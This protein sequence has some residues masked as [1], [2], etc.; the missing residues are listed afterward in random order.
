[1]RTP[2]FNQYFDGRIWHLKIDTLFNRLIVEVRDQK[3]LTTS[4]FQIDLNHLKVKDLEI[5]PAMTWFATLAGGCGN[6]LVFLDFQDQQNPG[7]GTLVLYDVVSATETLR[8]EAFVLEDLSDN[9]LSGYLVDGEEKRIVNYDLLAFSDEAPSDETATIQFP[10]FI[11]TDDNDFAVINDFLRSR[12]V[13]PAL[14][15]EYLELGVNIWITFYVQEAGGLERR[16]LWIQNEMVILE[17]TLDDKL[18]GV[19]FE[20]FICFKKHLIFVKNGREL[21]LYEI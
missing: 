21:C 17:E 20:S 19:S 7:P 16:L 18:Q 12:G 3:A 14:G 1:M 9:E 8:Q 15:A 11:S 2:D 6:V 13:N 5:H 4:H 10:F